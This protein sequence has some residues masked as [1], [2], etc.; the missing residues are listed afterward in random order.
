[1]KKINDQYN[2]RLKQGIA[3][4]QAQGAKVTIDEGVLIGRWIYYGRC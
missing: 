1:L 2:E 3:K 4:A